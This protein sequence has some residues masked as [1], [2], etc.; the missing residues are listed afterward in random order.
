MALSIQAKQRQ[1]SGKNAN[2]RARVAEM[3][4]A[5]LVRPD[6]NDSIM[7]EISLADMR[8]IVK[9]RS[10]RVDVD[11][12]GIGVRKAIVKSIDWNSLTDEWLHVDLMEVS[13]DRRIRARIPLEYKG[14]SEITLRGGMF[15]IMAD[16]LPVE[17]KVED[18]PERIVVDVATLAVGSFV[19][20]RDLTVPESV[21]V[22]SRPDLRVCEAKVSRTARGTAEE[23]EAA[24]PAAP[25]TPAAPADK[26]AAPKK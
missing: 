4:P 6:S 25:G 13:D 2:R 12:E 18:L 15:L 16:R 7:L 17:G 1:E 24:A 9:E 11:I 8:T 19:A 10:V 3:V 23:E 20:I 22:L 21:K 26:K 5:N 14:A